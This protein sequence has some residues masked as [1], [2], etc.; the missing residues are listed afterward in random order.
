MQVSV[1]AT[2]I[3]VADQSAGR[4]RLTKSDVSLRRAGRQLDTG[5]KMAK[6]REKGR[7]GGV[8]WNEKKL[9]VP[10]RE[11]VLWVSK[12]AIVWNEG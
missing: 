6:K 9:V 5:R 7:G 4:M 2:L 10:L 8:L 11:G 12:V 1:S 3:E